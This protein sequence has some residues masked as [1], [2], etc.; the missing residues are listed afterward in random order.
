MEAAALVYCRSTFCS[1]MPR[2]CAREGAGQM[3][4]RRV[5]RNIVCGKRA[6]TSPEAA[7]LAAHLRALRAAGD[8]VQRCKVDSL[9]HVVAGGDE[10]EALQRV[11]HT[12]SAEWSKLKRNGCKLTGTIDD[13]R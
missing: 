10:Q 8:A 4:S 12:I 1:A 13:R 2:Y 7:F 6:Q 3:A 5:S 9:G 11:H